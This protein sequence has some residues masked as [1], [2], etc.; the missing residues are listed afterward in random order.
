M[1]NIKNLD[2]NK[3]KID[4]KL[5]KNILI[6]NIRYVTRNS[7]KKLFYLIIH[8]INEYI[9]ESNGNKYLIPVPADESKDK[10]K[11]YYQIFLDQ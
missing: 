8:K 1:I 2:A 10:L 3:I 11:K 7:I 4:E 5:Q 9:G 6:C